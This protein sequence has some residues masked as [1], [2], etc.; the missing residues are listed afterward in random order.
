MQTALVTGAS[1]GIGLAISEFL[2]GRGIR[3][4]GLARRFQNSC[5]SIEDICDNFRKQ[6]SNMF[7][8]V[9]CDI[10]NVN[11][12]VE[13]IKKITRKQK[14][15]I[16]VNCAGIGVFG[17]HEQLNPYIIDEMVSVNLTAPLIITNLLLRQLKESQGIVINISSTAAK[18]IST[19]GCAYAATKA[20]LS[21]FSDSLF[22]EVRKTGVKVVTICPDITKTEF[23]KNADF[24][25]FDDEYCFLLAE[26]IVKAVD[27]I[28]SCREGI[29]A[30]ELTLMP[31]KFRIDRKKQ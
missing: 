24:K 5:D 31:Q 8:K 20:G 7:I 10:S 19:H 4:Y 13:C 29:V 18:K 22:H 25:E 3:V 16:L 14:I 30:R 9:K 28:L 11:E 26:D 27:F 6:D 21:H 12:L 2:A 23:Y 15:N 1:S 17:P